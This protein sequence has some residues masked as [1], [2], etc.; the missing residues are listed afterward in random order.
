MCV[1]TLS[2]QRFLLQPFPKG[3]SPLSGGML[4]SVEEF[5]LQGCV[6]EWMV[7]DGERLQSCFSQ[8]S[9]GELLPPLPPS[10]NPHLPDWQ[11]C[12]CCW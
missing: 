7:E 4:Q 8:A 5:V 11:V 3:I 6:M 12:D 10:E 9:E 1:K 2:D